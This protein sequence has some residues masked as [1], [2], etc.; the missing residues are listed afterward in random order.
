LDWGRIGGVWFASSPDVTEISVQVPI[1]RSLSLFGDCPT[2]ALVINATPNAVIVETR[3]MLLRFM[4]WLP[5]ARSAAVYST[6][7]F[8][9]STAALSHR[10]AWIS[11]PDDSPNAIFIK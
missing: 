8:D 4:V 3:R 6:E 7:K 11:T 2:V 1:K 10:L 9:A 5:L